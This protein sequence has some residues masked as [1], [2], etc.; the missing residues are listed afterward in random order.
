MALIPQANCGVRREFLMRVLCKLQ[1]IEIEIQSKKF[2]KRIT[3]KRVLRSV[4][5][6]SAALA[7]YN[8]HRA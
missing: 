2:A 5:L 7:R 6:A 8:R 3:H 4:E 1:K